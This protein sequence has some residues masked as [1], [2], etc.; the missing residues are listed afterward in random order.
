MYA[1]PM[2]VDGKRGVDLVVGSKSPNGMIS[3]LLS[4]GKGAV[5]RD[6]DLMCCEENAQLGVLWYE[7]PTN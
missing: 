7:N 1:L 4:P 3:L 2:D 6:L 5:V